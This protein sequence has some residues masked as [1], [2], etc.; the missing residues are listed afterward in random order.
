MLAVVGCDRLD[1]EQC[2]QPAQQKRAASR[3]RADSA[4]SRIPPPQVPI[5]ASG[6]GFAACLRSAAP[7]SITL[8][9]SACIWS[10]P[11]CAHPSP[12]S[13][14]VR[15]VPRSSATMGATLSYST[16]VRFMMLCSLS[17]TDDSYGL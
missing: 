4:L 7:A 12:I 16:S 2:E 9:I 14:Q 10:T 13:V 11:P 6:P 8:C 1:E 3:S 15:L 17:L 5:I